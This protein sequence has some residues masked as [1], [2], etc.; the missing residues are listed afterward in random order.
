MLYEQHSSSR[1]IFQP[2]VSPRPRHA[3]GAY[4]GAQ[5]SVCSTYDISTHSEVAHTL[6]TEVAH[7]LRNAARPSQCTVGPSALVVY[8][9]FHALRGCPAA[10]TR[11]PCL[12]HAPAYPR[13]PSVVTP[14]VAPTFRPHSP[15]PQPTR[16]P[17]SSPSN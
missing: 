2:A 16:P 8:R 11:P 17:L 12:V 1:F 15:F 14:P 3:A 7:T 13:T 5:P 6:R 4:S 10:A 9:P